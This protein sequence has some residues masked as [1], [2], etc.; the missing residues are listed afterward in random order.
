MDESRIIF[1]QNVAVEFY[2]IEDGFGPFECMNLRDV[3]SSI[4]ESNMSQKSL[5]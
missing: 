2:H 3:F 4:L 5:K 1:W